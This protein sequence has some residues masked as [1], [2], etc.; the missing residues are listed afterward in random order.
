MPELPEV[1]TVR[2]ALDEQLVG[3]TVTRVRVLTRSM[4]ALPGDPPTGFM[5]SRT[6]A[7]PVRMASTLLLKG[8]TIAATLRHGKQLALV[9]NTGASVC[10]QLG[11]TGSMQLEPGEAPAHTHVVW[12]TDDGRVLRFVDPR[13][14]GLVSAY[15]SPEALRSQRWSSLGPD[16]LT[17][18]S[19]AL[20]R[21]CSGRAR[22][23]KAVLLDQALVAGV[24]NIYAD[25]ALFKARVH[26]GCPAGS[27]G[28]QA[29]TKIAT[30][31]R[32]TLARAVEAGGSTIRDYRTPAGLDGGFQDQHLVYGR[33]NQ[34]CRRCRAELV[35]TRIAQ[36][37][38][39]F[40]PNCQ[41]LET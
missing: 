23:I 13:R 24:G 29:I 7:T 21:A 30:E 16:A 6:G 37:V 34:P 26:P 33:A 38:T 25:E 40:C 1:E 36:R 14:F 32:K 12:T 28:K 8:S 17:I 3:R 10:I 20:S 4:V 31:I 15:P 39:V 5:R 22:A 9:G 35:H 27:L 11:M 41:R 19:K 18:G 2:R